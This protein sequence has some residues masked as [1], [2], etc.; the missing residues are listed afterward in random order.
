M[1]HVALLPAAI[2]A[3]FFIHLKLVRRQGPSQPL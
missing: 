2:V 1:L 3:L